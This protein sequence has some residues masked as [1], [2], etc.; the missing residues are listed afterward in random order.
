MRS[1]N[2]QKM[3]DPSNGWGIC[4]CWLIENE[5]SPGFYNRPFNLLQNELKMY[6]LKTCK[7]EITVNINNININTLSEL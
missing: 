1:G 6:F 3:A 7:K 2:G 4:E 5:I